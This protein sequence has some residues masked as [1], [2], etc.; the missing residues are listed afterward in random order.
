MDGD[1]SFVRKSPLKDKIHSLHESIRVNDG[2]LEIM[3]DQIELITEILVN[4]SVKNVNSNG[5]KT[6][7][8]ADVESAFEEFMNDKLIIDQVINALQSSLDDM[9]RVREKSINNLLEV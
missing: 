2:A 1:I 3:Q 9:N 5:R 4:L 8:K 7:M 6:I